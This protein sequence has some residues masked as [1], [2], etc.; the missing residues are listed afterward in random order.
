MFSN[1]DMLTKLILQ[2]KSKI[3]EIYL[4]QNKLN[5]NAENFYL[6]DLLHW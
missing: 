1:I 6:P 5:S 2:F 3:S 4:A